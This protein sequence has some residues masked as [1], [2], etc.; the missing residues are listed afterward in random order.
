MT[1]SLH[2]VVLVETKRASLALIFGLKT[3]RNAHLRHW[4]S[5]RCLADVSRRPS[6][7]TGLARR[8]DR[9]ALAEP[10]Q[11]AALARVG[12]FFFVLSAC[13]MVALRPA[14]RRHFAVRAG[15]ACLR[16]DVADP[17]GG[18]RLALAI[19]QI[20]AFLAPRRRQRWTGGGQVTWRH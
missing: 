19:R 11:R 2:F 20:V 13:T 15:L 4:G 8:A 17:V 6:A 16:V 18:T 5:A 9:V 12:G 10:V 3:S 7:W 14:V 1:L